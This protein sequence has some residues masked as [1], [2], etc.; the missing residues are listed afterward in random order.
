MY[1]Y[2]CWAI[3]ASYCSFFTQLYSPQISDLFILQTHICIFA[4]WKPLLVVATNIAVSFLGFREF[5]LARLSN[6]HKNV[7]C[8]QGRAI[9]MQHQISR[10][11]AIYFLLITLSGNGNGAS[12]FCV[13]IVL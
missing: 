5:S 2:L 3:P 9:L 1:I 13:S 8:K 12:H 10:A 7:T 4:I 11:G 6:I